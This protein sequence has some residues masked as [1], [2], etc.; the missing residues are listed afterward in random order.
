MSQEKINILDEFS[1]EIIENRQ[2]IAS[3]LEDLASKSSE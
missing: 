2:N 3:R 1:S